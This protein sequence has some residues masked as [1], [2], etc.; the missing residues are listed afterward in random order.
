[1]RH[2]LR[3]IVN[4][5][6]GQPTGA[7]G[8]SLVEL[9]ITAPLLILMILSMVEV[10]FVAN[11]YL[12]LMDVVRGAARVAVNLDPTAW[13]DADTR[14]QQ[15]LD[16]DGI[17]KNP[18][19][20]DPI[21]DKRFLL[22]S[23]G[24]TEDDRREIP[25]ARGLP[26]FGPNED[27]WGYGIG[28][29]QASYGFFDNIVCQ[30]TKSM[31]PLVFNDYSRTSPNIEEGDPPNPDARDD[32]VVS[33]ISYT[34][35]DYTKPLQ[36]Y[37]SPGLNYGSDPGSRDNTWVT[38]TGRWP[39][40]NRYCAKE[41]GGIVYGDMRDPFD[42]E[43]RDYNLAWSNGHQGND[44]NEW[45][46][47][48]WY[49]DSSLMAMKERITSST[50]TT[51]ILS[52]Y[53]DVTGSHPEDNQRIRGFIFTGTQK[54]TGPDEC[55]GSRFTVQDI[56]NRLNLDPAWNPKTPNSGLVLVEVFWQYHPLVLGPIFE[57][58]TG[59][60]VNDPILWVWGFFPVP[61]VESTA[62]PRP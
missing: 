54:S 36:P 48:Y 33:A 23:I 52:V 35:V 3:K 42:W 53:D 28:Q 38:V 6:D 34:K 58:F 8:Q 51:G 20:A 22:K 5:L 15:R 50:G 59:S 56:E 18:D 7:R 25:R 17:Y 16:C 14:N 27:L 37:F 31:S 29:E 57:G 44:P 9:A 30:V 61:A 41:I 12:I 11:D 55:Y 45:V 40:A 32:I 2:T 19:P 21:V 47:K 60:K 24:E 1:M 26:D 43:R 10:G 46:P 62:T 49:Y 39:L 4:V 13:S